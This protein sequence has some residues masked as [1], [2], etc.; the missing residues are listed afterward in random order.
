VPG[1]DKSKIRNPNIEIRNKLEIR[2][3]NSQQTIAFPHRLSSFA[4]RKDTILVY[5]LWFMISNFGFV[6]DFDIRIS[7]L[8]LSQSF[9][10]AGE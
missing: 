4:L 10:S 1:R 7:D 9:P 3:R 6:S 8:L 2:K 5:G